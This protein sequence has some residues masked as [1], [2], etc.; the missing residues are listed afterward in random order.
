MTTPAVTEPVESRPRFRE[1]QVLTAPELAREQDYQVGM[2][3]RHLVGAHS[4]GIV[5]GLALAGL[6]E[7]FGVQPGVAVD[8][9]GRELVLKQPVLVRSVELGELESAGADV[10]LLYGRVAATPAARGRFDCGPG[11]HSRWREEPCLRFSEVREPLEPRRPPGVT[12]TS[13]E[14]EPHA[15]P[16]DGN[17]PA[18]PVYLGRLTPSAAG[19]PGMPA[20]DVDLGRRPYAGL[21]GESVR[22]PRGSEGLRIGGDAGGVAVELRDAAGT[23]TEP[24]SVDAAGDTTVRADTAL[25]GELSIAGIGA[26]AGGLSLTPLAATPEAPAPWRAYRTVVTEGQA[27]LD[28]LRLE[29]GHPGDKG[30]PLRYALGIGSA[31]ADGTFER[32]LTLMSN[33]TVVVDGDVSVEGLVSYGPLAAD[34][35]NPRFRSAVL[36]R[37]MRGITQAGSSL[38]QGYAAELSVSELSLGAD[39]VTRQVTLDVTLTNTGPVP[40]S[41]VRAAVVF[42]GDADDEVVRGLLIDPAID[43]EPGDF[44]E[45][46]GTFDLSGT[47]ANEIS[48]TVGAGGLGPAGTPVA[49]SEGSTVRFGSGP[50]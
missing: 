20:Y 28:Q 14:F 40:I 46:G 2:R 13:L 36:L 7:G 48:V 12:R 27:T 15:A 29:V 34:P 37:W 19:G 5:Y 24:L 38:D 10:W 47:S 44:E 25:S 23:L 1:R 17:V 6:P 3:R 8:G 16:P 33:C 49:D 22:N 21:V 26:D 50:I 45:L 42:V 43:M 41:S 4:W 39:D 32:Y 18:W 31:R 35:D 11:R 9:F 30:D